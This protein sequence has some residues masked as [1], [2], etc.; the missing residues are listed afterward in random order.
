M[1]YYNTTRISGPQLAL[2]YKETDAKDKIILQTLKSKG[3]PMTAWDILNLFPHF[4]I[5]SIRRSLNT[6]CVKEKKID[7]IKFIDGPKGRP[8]GLYQIKK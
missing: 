3:I 8:V 2:A 7:F 6:L 4:E 1:N 5:T